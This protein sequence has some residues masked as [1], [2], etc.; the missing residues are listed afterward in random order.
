MEIDLSGRCGCTAGKGFGGACGAQPASFVLASAAPE[1]YAAI[2]S[3]VCKGNGGGAAYYSR[4]KAIRMEGGTGSAS[5][6]PT[7]RMF[8][9]GDVDYSSNPTCNHAIAERKGVCPVAC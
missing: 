7:R 5:A 2:S 8:E 6:H 1:L 4:K 3:P 9:L